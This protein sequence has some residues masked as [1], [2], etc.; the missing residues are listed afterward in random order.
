MNN[1]CPCFFSSFIESPS[2]STTSLTSSLNQR[3][4]E[5]LNRPDSSASHRPGVAF[6]A[7]PDS[8]DLHRPGAAS[9][10]VTKLDSQDRTGSGS[11]PPLDNAILV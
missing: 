6:M 9:L 5:S 1:F 4:S 3:G 11:N 2:M 10:T 7:R 8:S